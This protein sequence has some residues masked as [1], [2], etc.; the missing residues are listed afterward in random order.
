MDPDK[1]N[2]PDTDK[3]NYIN[4]Y[5]WV[6]YLRCFSVYIHKVIDRQKNHLISIG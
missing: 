1:E 6:M 5:V 4:V 3:K 2:D